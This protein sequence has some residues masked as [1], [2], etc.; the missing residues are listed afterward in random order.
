MPCEHFKEALIEAAAT[1]AAL[2]GPFGAHLAECACCREAFAQEQSLFAAIDAGLYTRANVEVP[3]AVL[4][5]V[6]AGVDK[7]I[8]TPSR[9]W[10]WVTWTSAALAIVAAAALLLTVIFAHSPR[11]AVPADSMANRAAA[12]PIPPS[13]PMPS[14]S[15]PRED[16]A[17]LV[18]PRRSG[19]R[20]SVPT[21]GVKSQG[22]IPEI[23]VPRDQELLL[24][25]YA[26]QW[27]SRRRAPLVGGGAEQAAVALLEV[28][29][30]QI[31]ELDVRLLNG[32]P[33]AK[34]LAN[35]PENTD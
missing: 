27:G 14:S 10:G 5:R 3:A 23:L 35:A 24:T 34:T 30:I 1:G 18:R 12:S 32:R 17:T 26:R 9:W 21:H 4:A 29:P 20:N 13:V 16:V 19:T 28:P 31:P 15:E 25:S 33:L 11:P 22:P 8:V 2:P 7:A 6:R